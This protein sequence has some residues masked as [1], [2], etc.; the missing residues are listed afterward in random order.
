MIAVYCQQNSQAMKGNIQA[1]GTQELSSISLTDY[2]A[3]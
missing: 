3:P 1:S 2:L